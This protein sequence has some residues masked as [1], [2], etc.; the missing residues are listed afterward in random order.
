MSEITT[1][2]IN[3]AL[4]AK[5]ARLPL[6]PRRPVSGSMSGQHKSPHRGSS[7]EF[8]EYRKYAPG[9]D[10]RRL[11]WRVLARSDRFYMKEF[12]AETNLRC[13][14]LLDCSGS[15]AYRSGTTSKFDCA[16]QIAATLLYLVIQ[17]GDAAGLVRIRHDGLDE[18]PAKRNPAHVR[19]LLEFIDSASPTGPTGLIPAIHEVAEKI[20]ERALVIILSDCFCPL[21]PLLEALRHLDFKKHDVAVF[22]IIDP[23]ELNFPFERA[24]RFADLES[25][26]HLTTEPALIRT[27]YLDALARHVEGLRDACAQFRADFLQTPADRNPEEI[28]ASFLADRLR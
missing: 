6:Q 2:W 12:E 7:V 18:L 14:L 23:D 10:I 20:R 15:M 11:D 24:T 28:L 22:Q 17:Q 26:S 8:A 13:H 25:P 3:P 4:V 21:P 1:R 9:D 5:L 16:R 27:D 19:T